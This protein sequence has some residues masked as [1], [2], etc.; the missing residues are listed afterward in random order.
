MQAITTKYIGPS[1]VRGSRVKATALG[2][3]VTLGW[4]DSLNSDAN[5]K[6]AAQVLANKLGWNYGEWIEGH[7]PDGSSVWV[8]NAKH[9]VERF[10]VD[11]P[12]GSVS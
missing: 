7:L 11:C 2:G 6:C 9:G 3:S 5:H 4:N 12:G 1:N 8:C 10:E